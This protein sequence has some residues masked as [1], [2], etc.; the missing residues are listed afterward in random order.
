MKIEK[1]KPLTKKQVDQLKQK[2]EEEK[3][4]LIF[5]NNLSAEEFGLATDD[6]ND[7]TDA[8]IADYEGSHLLRFR[9]RE[10]FYIKKIDKALKKIEK[11]E[12]GECIDC[13]GTIR[14]ERLWARP[15]AEMCI[16]CKEEAEKEESHSIS[17][18]QSK[19]YGKT[20]DLNVGA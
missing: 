20:L 7:E 2:L 3:S 12:Y 8:A 15:T 14:F 11:G 4:S 18:R 10:V 17:G 13:G 5:S 1:H 6:V 9:N 16:Q 19:S